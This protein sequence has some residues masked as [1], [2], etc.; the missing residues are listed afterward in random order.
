MLHSPAFQQGECTAD[1]NANTLL[2]QGLLDV[3]Y[4]TAYTLPVVLLNNLRARS[5]KTSSG[6]DDSELQLRDVDVRLSLPQAP[7][8]L[9][10]VAAQESGQQSGPGTGQPTQG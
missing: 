4:G 3:G 5:T 10:Q 9:R 2:Q 1:P 6:V 7:E 8:V